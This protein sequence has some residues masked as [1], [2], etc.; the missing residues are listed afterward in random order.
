MLFSMYKVVT[1]EIMEPVD[2]QKHLR[3]KNYVLLVILVGLM[4][5]LYALSFVKFGMAVQG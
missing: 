4:V 3:I 5:L 1:N 2:S